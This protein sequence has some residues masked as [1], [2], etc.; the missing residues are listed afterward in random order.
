MSFT[1]IDPHP[2]LDS[3]AHYYFWKRRHRMRDAPAGALHYLPSYPVE[4]RI[5]QS[6][7]TNLK[8][9]NPSQM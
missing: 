9:E 2:H 5:P 4:N 1:H 7:D 6:I 3:V 8:R